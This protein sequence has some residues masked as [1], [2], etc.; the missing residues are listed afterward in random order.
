MQIMT[1]FLG[2]LAIGICYLYF[3]RF[4]YCSRVI[5]FTSCLVCITIPDFLYFATNTLT[6]I[7][8]LLLVVISLWALD[9][10]SEQLSN[11]KVQEFCLGIL[12]ALPFLCRSIGIVLI[13]SGFLFWFCR[14]GSVRWL[15]IGIIVTIL[16]WLLWIFGAIGDLKNDPVNG[17]YTDYLSWW[18]ELGIPFMT[19][20]ISFNLLHAVTGSISLSTEGL[21]ALL[22]GYSTRLLSVTLIILG[23]IPWAA[24]ILHKEKS[25]SLKWFLIGYFLLIC[26]WPWPPYRFLIP[27][28]PFLIAYFFVGISDILKKHISSKLI[29]LY[30]ISIS[31]T[32]VITNILLVVEHLEIRNHTNFPLRSSS[33]IVRW[34]SYKNLFEWLKMNTSSEET[35]AYGLDTM[36]YLYTGRSGI[37]PFFSRP[38]SLF[39]GDDYPATGTVKEL[40]IILNLY[41]PKYL[42]QTPM[43]Y[44]SEEK[45]F[46]VLLDNLLKDCPNCLVPAYIGK[47][48]RFKVYEVND[49]EIE[50]LIH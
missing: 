23:S 27:I 4:K 32:L 8:F 28:L 25:K 16:P 24:I 41:R 43:P 10:Y 22:K 20:I 48:S 36:A 44:F 40:G 19:K 31:F 21:I 29:K 34:N 49:Q 38:T 9:Y 35:I 33:E 37:R 14:I 45:P 50:T 30:I 13:I 1:S 47:D 26:I 12:L 18:M 6:E 3:V 46:D 7:P 39:Y 42:V 5:A 11:N 17:Y 15:I 2:S